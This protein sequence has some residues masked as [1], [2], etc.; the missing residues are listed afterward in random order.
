MLSFQ[1]SSGF[2]EII[3][4]WKIYA[5]INTDRQTGTFLKT[6]LD[7]QL[8]TEKI[9]VSGLH[10]FCIAL[11]FVQPKISLNLLVNFI[12]IFS[13]VERSERYGC[14]SGEGAY[15]ILT[16]EWPEELSPTTLCSDLAAAEVQ[17][18]LDRDFLPGQAAYAPKQSPHRLSCPAA[19]W[20]EGDKNLAS[21]QNTAQVGIMPMV[22]S[23]EP[24]T[25][26]RVEKRGCGRGWGNG[27]TVLQEYVQELQLLE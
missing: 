24:A 22:H 21:S 19:A 4:I 20:A 23:R 13:L 5:N 15:S 18:N 27:N 16:E 6:F 10:I 8:K 9:Q 2:I 3:F 17:R 1:F 25:L 26:L 14:K 11:L 7:T 12:Q